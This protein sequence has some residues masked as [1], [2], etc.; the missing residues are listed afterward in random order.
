M[1]TH[2]VGRGRGGWQKA[3]KCL[4]QPAL[5]ISV[6]SDLLYPVI[7]Q[8]NLARELPNAKHFVTKSDSG[9]DGFLLDQDQILPISLAFLES[10]TPS[11]ISGS[12]E[13][14]KQQAKL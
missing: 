13:T 9:H 8:E 6:S 4:V 1:D 14:R 11:I 12:P 10:L 3:L 2:D 7:E 5:V